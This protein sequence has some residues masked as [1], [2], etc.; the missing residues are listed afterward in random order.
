M[1]FRDKLEHES[2]GMVGIS[3]FTCGGMSM[4][5]SSIKHDRGISIKIKHADVERGLHQEWYHG[6]K[7]IVEVF[8]SASQFA[9]LIT[10]PNTGD[11]VPCTIRGIDGKQMDAPPYYGQNEIFNSEL[12]EKFS[13]AMSGADDLIRD[14]D[15]MLSSKGAMKVADKKELLGKISSLVQHIRA[16]MPFMHKQFTRAMDKTVVTAK[17][18]V[19]EFYTSTILKMG[20]KALENGIVPEQ[21]Q[22]ED[23]TTD[24]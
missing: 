20:K 16:N 10:T 12:Q 2:Y 7:T 9:Q 6:N 8:L 1:D 11:G 24:R 3:H 4:F 19:E 15:K 5:G 18:E 23:K 14:A 22:I 17:A 21:P 13:E